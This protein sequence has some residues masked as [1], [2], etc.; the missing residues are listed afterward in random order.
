MKRTIQHWFSLFLLM[1]LAS[2]GSVSAQTLSI[3]DFDIEAGGTAKVTID[4]DQAGK[5]LLAFQAD[6][7]LPEGLTVKGKPKAVSGTMTD[8]F[9]EETE[10]TVTFANNRIVVYSGDGYAF[11]E[12]ATSIVTLTMQAA[13]NFAGGV[14]KMEN[15]TIS[16]EG[17]ILWQSDVDDPELGV[18]TS[19][20]LKPMDIEVTYDTDQVLNLEYNGEVIGITDM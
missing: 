2:I 17:N 7:V 10:P 4:L 12:D 19:I 15:I 16:A 5:V 18:P 20:V 6:I 3:A 1:V 9:E 11:N 13:D 8:E 14:I